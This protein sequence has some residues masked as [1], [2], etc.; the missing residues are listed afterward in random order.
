L[1]H[2]IEMHVDAQGNQYLAG[3]FHQT[4]D[5]DPGSG[6]TLLTAAG[7][8]DAFVMK[9]D[10]A[11]NLLWARSFGGPD[12]DRLNA[13]AVS[14]SGEVYLGGN[15]TGTADFDPGASDHLITSHG[16]RDAYLLALSTTGEFAWAATFGELASDELND[17]AF[18]GNHLLVT[19]SFVRTV[20][21]DPGPGEALLSSNGNLDAFVGKYTTS[22]EL[23]WVRGL[24]GTQQDAGERIAAATGG[25]VVV[26]GRFGGTVDFDPGPA[27]LALT[28]AGGYDMFVGSFDSMGSLRWAVRAGADGADT[29]TDMAL[30]SAGN[31][32][33]TGGFFDTVDFDPSSAV[34]SAYAGE[35]SGAFV[36]K[37]SSLG[38]FLWVQ[39]FRGSINDSASGTAVT[40][41]PTDQVFATGSL[42]GTIGFAG[43]SI[44]TF[45]GNDPF[46]VKLDSNNGGVGWVRHFGGIY[47]DLPFAIATDHAGHVLVGGFFLV[48]ADFDPGESAAYLD[49][50]GGGDAFLLKLFDEAPP[51]GGEVV[52]RH[53]FYNNSAFD[54]FQAAANTS[55]D[56]AIASDKSVLLPGETAGLAHYTSYSR[57]VNGIMIDMTGLTDAGGLSA[58]DF[59]FRRGN[60][61]EI[62]SWTAAPAPTQIHVR[63]GAGV[64]GSDRITLIFSDGAIVGTWL[65]VTVRSTARTGLPIPDKF[66]VGNSVGESGNQSGSTLV[67]GSDFAGARSNPHNFLTPAPLADPFDFNRD[68]L[69]NAADLLLVRE[70]TNS[71]A[72]ALKLISPPASD[73]AAAKSVAAKAALDALFAEWGQ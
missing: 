64:G 22:G 66:Y 5:F 38:Q 26:A 45:G 31:V 27:T 6:E 69:V 8:S 39:S 37:L 11:N 58:S 33:T 72:T 50:A 61:H 17:I 7:E 36:W 70:H 51:S 67:D 63:L 20:D 47:E 12:D 46:V 60:S 68:A 55:D 10:A 44:S 49:S 2:I 24:G 19:G 43:T 59:L 3:E 65:E 57:G 30:D 73:P 15:F 28:S 35:N 1:D 32:I 48:R 21:F 40:I 71:I 53:L 9:L 56:G 23:V 52:A 4:V 13:L 29:I 16:S 18:G 25:N 54:G 34:R 41:S 42:Y 14:D 62:A